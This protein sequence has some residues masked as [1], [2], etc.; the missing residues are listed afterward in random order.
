[1]Y[2]IYLFFSLP[3]DFRDTI[4]A[5]SIG[6]PI[7]GGIANFM[8]IGV[9]SRLESSTRR[10]KHIFVIDANNKMPK[11]K[12]FSEMGSLKFELKS[13]GYEDSVLNDGYE[14]ER[15][16]VCEDVNY[17]KSYV[18]DN[19]V[20]AI[21]LSLPIKTSRKVRDILRIADYH[22]ARLKLLADYQ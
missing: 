9:I 18:E 13:N 11:E 22:G 7:A 6:F 20:D 5:F 10:V 15:S 8:V 1:L 14:G 17:M 2:L 12:T 19:R 16:K 4:I 21:L 3:R